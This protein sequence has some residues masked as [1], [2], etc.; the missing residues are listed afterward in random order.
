MRDDRPEFSIVVPTWNGEGRIAETLRSLTEQ[1]FPARSFEVIVVDD[2][3][4]DRTVATVQ[5]FARRHPHIA[6][7]CRAEPHG[8]VNSA[9][10]AGIR[11]STGKVIGFVDDDE[12]VQP[13]H[14]ESVRAAL[15]SPLGAESG[16]VGGPATA[17]SASFRTCPTCSIGDATL[18][19]AGAGTSR[20]LLGGNMYI[21]RSVF[22]EVGLFD[23]DISGR[24]DENEWFARADRGFLY[25]EQLSVRHRRDHLSLR[26]LLVTGYR[27]G[28]ATPV[29]QAQYDEVY[30]QSPLPQELA[31]HL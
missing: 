31:H 24:G 15:D 16:G 17:E 6:L 23:E 22:D 8:G 26:Q 30:H 1:R 29:A 27:Q 14:L 7:T 18:P 28:R 9:R 25:D 10:N 19:I 20:R 13:D 4:T 3:S 21:K 12:L 11:A 5:E 2:G